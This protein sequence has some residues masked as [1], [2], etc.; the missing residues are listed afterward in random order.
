LL[1][2]EPALDEPELEP[3]PKLLESLLDEEDPRLPLDP[4]PVEDPDDE[5]PMPEDVPEDEEPMPVPASTPRA[6]T[7]LSSSRPVAERLLDFWNS[8]RACCVLGPST[9]SSG[10]GS[11]PLLFRAACT[12]LTFSFDMLEP[13]ARLLEVEVSSFCE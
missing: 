10:P 12:A 6:L 11:M 13:D 3:V 2:D 9:P 5:L 8:R 1:E 7:V 4:V